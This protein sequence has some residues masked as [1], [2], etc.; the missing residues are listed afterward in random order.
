M[1]HYTWELFQYLRPLK[2]QY[3]NAQTRHGLPCAP[4]CLAVTRRGN[5]SS[6]TAAQDSDC[7]APRVPVVVASSPPSWRV[8]H[9]QDLILRGRFSGLPPRTHAGPG[10]R[11]LV[12][13]TTARMCSE[14]GRKQEGAGGE[15]LGQN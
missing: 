9:V 15:K 7:E 5:L 3:S 1:N 11:A 10:S 8:A 2:V 14:D 12:D 6:H 13:V 4:H